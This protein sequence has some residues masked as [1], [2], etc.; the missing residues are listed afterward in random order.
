M[1][2]R[3]DGSSVLVIVVPVSAAGALLVITISVVLIGLLK[4]WT[5]KLPSLSKCLLCVKFLV[6]KTDSRR[7]VHVQVSAGD[8]LEPDYIQHGEQR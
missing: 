2:Q 7:S 5:C 3:P 8:R 1:T 4:I 6:I